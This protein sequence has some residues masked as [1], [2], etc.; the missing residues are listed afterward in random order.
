[1]LLG[2]LP[3]FG[4]ERLLLEFQKRSL[5]LCFLRKIRLTSR[6]MIRARQV[7]LTVPEGRVNVV[8]GVLVNQ[9]V[10]LVTTDLVYRSMAVVTEMRGWI[11]DSEIF[12]E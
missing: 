11:W 4:N 8:E 7:R 3:L 10:L 9:P 1:M 5:L 2:I 6:M 12:S